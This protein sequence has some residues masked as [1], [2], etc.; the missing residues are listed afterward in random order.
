MQDA[1]QDAMQA[2]SKGRIE[3]IIGAMFSGKSSELQRRLRRFMLAKKSCFLVQY[4]KDTRYADVAV[5]AAVVDAKADAKADGADAESR[6]SLVTHDHCVL[7]AHCA[8]SRLE[9]AAALIA[10]GTHVVAVDE[11]QFFPDAA[12]VCR[13]WANAGMIVLCAALDATFERVPFSVTAQLVAEAERVDKLTAV[14]VVCGD[15]RALWS[16]RTTESKQLEVIGG[17]D[18]Y[19]PLCRDCWKR[20]E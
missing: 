10:P 16:H 1:M 15:D 18:A 5:A 9:D 6:A 20:V 12:A 14:C 4:V 13:A 8:V 19:Q 3:L 7:P 17:A 2:Q 11:A